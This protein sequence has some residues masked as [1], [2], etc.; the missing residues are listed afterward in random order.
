MPK[1][2]TKAGNAEI[3]RQGHTTTNQHGGGPNPP[4][5]VKKS[6]DLKVK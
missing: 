4:T 2:I 3:I 5:K 6:R 1:P